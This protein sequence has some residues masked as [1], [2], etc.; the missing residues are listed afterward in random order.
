LTCA[1]SRFDPFSPH[2]QVRGGRIGGS[3][4][5]AS[6]KAKYFDRKFAQEWYQKTCLGTK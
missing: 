1:M 6:Q 4:A 3:G 5:V 2:V